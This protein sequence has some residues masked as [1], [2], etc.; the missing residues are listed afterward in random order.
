MTSTDS[1]PVV[2]GEGRAIVVVPARGGSKRF[3]RK[4]IALLAGRPLLAYSIAAAQQ[5]RS[6][7][8]VYVSTEDDE[9]AAVAKR[10]GAQV[11][12]RRPEE[13]AGDQV[14]ADAAVADLVR[15]LQGEHGLNID[16][17]V[18]IQPTS[19]FVTAAHID[20]AVELLR[21]EPDLD[22]VTT[23]AE[24][25]HRHHPYNL[26]FMK[27]DGRWEFLF[28][29]ERNQARSRQ[30]KPSAL[31]FGNLFAARTETML[32]VG[33][34]GRVKGA[35]LIDPIY[36]WDIDHEWELRVAEYLLANGLVNLPHIVP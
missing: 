10:Y 14:P 9:I 13:L 26:A 34:F 19:P 33:R 35:V 17:V 15:R 28:E 5:A 18:L 11:P 27:A 3:P 16:M 8:A 20:A 24:L 7:D 32:S 29:E 1:Q 23:M 36:S 30:S 22:S 4:N 31:K 2:S 12:F 6:I 25:D 21:A